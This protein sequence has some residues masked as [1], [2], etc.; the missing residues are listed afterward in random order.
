MSAPPP[1]TPRVSYGRDRNGR[2]FAEL[3]TSTGERPWL[4][5]IRVRTA[6]GWAYDVLPGEQRVW[7]APSREDPLELVI[8]SV[9]RIGEESV[10]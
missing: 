1:P 5:T 2:R 10:P 6:A 3:A 7:T 4:W 9:N 8:T